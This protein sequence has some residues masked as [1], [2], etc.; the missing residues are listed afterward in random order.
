MKRR[1]ANRQK[2]R[3][4]LDAMFHTISRLEIILFA[5]LTSEIL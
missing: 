4:G 3:G 5:Q 2:E 1:V